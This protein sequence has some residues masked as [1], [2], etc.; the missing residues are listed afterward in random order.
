[1]AENDDAA[2]RGVARSR[3]RDSKRERRKKMV[4]T[5]RGVFT[6]NR[7][8]GERAE[9][10]RAKQISDASTPSPDGKDD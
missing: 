8:L 7:V 3:R 6:I 10:A 1:M 5:G 4:V 9:K 2:Y